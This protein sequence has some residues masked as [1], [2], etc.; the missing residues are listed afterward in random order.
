MCN[1]LL[2][3]RPDL[4]KNAGTLLSFPD[5]ENRVGMEI[6]EIMRPVCWGCIEEGEA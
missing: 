2:G 5:V 6:P 1:T 3:S 4:M